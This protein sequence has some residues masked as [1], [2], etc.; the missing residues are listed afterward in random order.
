MFSLILRV[1]YVLVST[2]LGKTAATLRYE[3]NVVECKAFENRI[4]N[5]VIIPG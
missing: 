2:W 1:T 3:K 5:H 4:R